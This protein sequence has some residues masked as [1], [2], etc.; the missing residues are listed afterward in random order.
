MNC[1]KVLRKEKQE[2]AVQFQTRGSS[3]QLLSLQLIH[4]FFNFTPGK[5]KC[6]LPCTVHVNK[7]SPYSNSNYTC[8]LVLLSV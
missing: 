6:T 3:V 5:Q 8:T 1:Y 2:F 7:M 4:Y